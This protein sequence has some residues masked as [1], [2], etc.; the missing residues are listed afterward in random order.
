MPLPEGHPDWLPP[1]LRDLVARVSS[2]AHMDYEDVPKI[3][4]AKSS[5]KHLRLLRNAL[6]LPPEVLE[7]ILKEAND[8][9]TDPGTVS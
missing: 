2:T 7:A 6:Q 5:N 1:R 3:K 9:R 4:R 8:G